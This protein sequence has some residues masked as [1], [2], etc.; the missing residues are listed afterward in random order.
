[1][2]ACRING[3]VSAIALALSVL[4]PL[5]ARAADDPI[6]GAWVGTVTQEGQDPFETR[7]TFVSPKGGISRYPSFPCGGMLLGGRKGEGYEYQETLT[8]GGI[9]ESPTGCIGGTVSISVNG[10]KMKF[11]WAGSYEGRDIVATGE[12]HREAK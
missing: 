6:V 12:L 11:D 9:D 7:L 8:W 2:T 10:D 4:V 1:M 5:A 3:T